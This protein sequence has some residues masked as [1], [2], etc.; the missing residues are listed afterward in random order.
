MDNIAVHMRISGV[1]V[2]DDD[3]NSRRS[4]AISLAT[5]W[6]KEKTVS[7][8]LS[9]AADIAETLGGDGNPSL[10]LGAEIQKA[11]QKKSSSFLYEE[12]PLEVGVC[13]GMAMVSLLETIPGTSG[14]LIKDVYATALWSA[15]AYQ[16]VLDT[17]RRENLRREV[18]DAAYDWVA[19]TAE[20]ARER[21]DVPDPSNLSITINEINVATSNFKEA[22]TN[23][24]EALRRNSAL[25][26]EE[27]DFLWWA[28]LGRSRLLNRQ[29]SAITE[30][31]RIVAAGIEGARMLRRL[32]CEVHREIVLRSLDKDPELDLVEML[33]AVGD[34]RVTLSAEC[35]QSNIAAHPTVFPLLHALV[36][37]EVNGS[38]AAVKRRVSEWGERALLEAG[39]ARMIS[40]GASKL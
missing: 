23:T 24:V 6:G 36:T 29:L 8:I 39:F 27:L 12:R 1:T 14:W 2:N 30:P 21:T 5:N 34:D 7:T 20:K 40:Q 18:L 25:D 32:P 31:T 38:G 37:G 9:K 28:Q 16:P 26:R 35:F 22:M 11:I 17:E 33:A 10:A 3:V 19:T 4:A 15:L 13:A